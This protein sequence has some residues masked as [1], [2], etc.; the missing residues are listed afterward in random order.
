[1][2]LNR[3]YRSVYRNNSVFDFEDE[4]GSDPLLRRYGVS[5]TVS[6]SYEVQA[7][8]AAARRLNAEA[9]L[10]QAQAEEEAKLAPLRAVSEQ[11]R[12]INDLTSQRSKLEEDARRRTAEANI[13]ELLPKAATSMDVDRLVAE[14]ADVVL[15]PAQMERINFAKQ[16]FIE[17]DKADLRTKL[18]GVMSPEDVDK[19]ELWAAERQLLGD[20]EVKTMLDIW[21]GVAA[22]KGSAM[23]GLTQLGAQSMPVTRQGEFDVARAENIVETLGRTDIRTLSAA[24]RGL[25]QQLANIDDPESPEATAL[26]ADLTNINRQIA[27][28]ANRSDQQTTRAA[29]DLQSLGGNPEAIDEDLQ[30]I[31]GIKK[32]APAPAPTEPAPAAPTQAPTAA[33]SAPTPTEQKPISLEEEIAQAAEADRRERTLRSVQPK[34]E[35]R[36]A[37]K[38]SRI[39]KAE[40]RAKRK[41]LIDE[42]ERLNKAITDA[43]LGEETDV[44]KRAKARIAEINQ[45]LGE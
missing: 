2:S 1:M 45:E 33:A 31:L 36:R 14:N 13:N 30:G 16:K 42:R 25:Q 12:V 15:S 21:R 18:P 37:E 4:F 20:A 11:F 28:V 35:A 27:S 22:K 41:T 7:E 23:K 26:Q 5:P 8:V 24:Q 10:A 44:V 38:E 19:W 17:R 6:R 43:G 29:L 39:A 3:P 32:P 34:L 40:N 9:E